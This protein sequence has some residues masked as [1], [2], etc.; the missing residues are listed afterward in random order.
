MD[1]DR[2]KQLPLFTDL[3]KKELDRVAGWADE[4]E[5]PPGK[6]L[7]EEGRFAHEFFVIEE[8]TA[9]VTSD[10]R[11][12]A[13]L[14]PGD[15]FGEIALMEHMRRTA[16]VVTSSPVRAMVMFARE[17]EAM[18]RELPE[19]TARIRAAMDARREEDRRRTGG[20]T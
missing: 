7:I 9:E 8:G 13:N 19:V 16:S 20:D 17:F 15:F 2:L 4:V 10:G 1:A 3:S 6:H 12:V 18:E 14:G 5:L 11:H